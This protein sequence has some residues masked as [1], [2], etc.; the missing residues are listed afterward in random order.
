[1][2]LSGSDASI[3]A[4]RDPHLPCEAVVAVL[5]TDS[6]LILL[7]P[8]G[9]GWLPRKH[10]GTLTLAPRPDG[11]LR[12]T[13]ELPAP[14]HANTEALGVGGQRPHDEGET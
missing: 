7:A 8:L 3:R 9:G 6:I 5:L 14:L 12:V 13:V 10:D 11:G 2:E 4:A 1:M